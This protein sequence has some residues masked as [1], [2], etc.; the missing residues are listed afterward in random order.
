HRAMWNLYY[1]RRYGHAKLIYEAVLHGGD[2]AAW[3][4]VWKG[5]TKDLQEVYRSLFEEAYGFTLTKED[6]LRYRTD[7]DDFFYAA[8]YTRAY[9]MADLMQ[10]AARERFGAAWYEKPEVGKWLRETYWAEGT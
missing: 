9:V 6:A 10:E 1:M 2:P 4:D 7:V 5:E 8:D 3:R